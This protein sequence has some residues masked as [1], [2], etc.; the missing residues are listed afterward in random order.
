[1]RFYRSK[2]GKKFIATEPNRCAVVSKSASGT[3]V[4]TYN[5]PFVK[6]NGEVYDESTADEFFKAYDEITM[7][8]TDIS[9]SSK[10]TRGLNTLLADADISS[11]K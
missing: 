3:S 7:V 10:K 1:M 5:F 11:Y 2:N 9:S 4:Q 6:L 8:M